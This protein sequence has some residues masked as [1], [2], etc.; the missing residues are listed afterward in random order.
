MS[1]ISESQYYIGDCIKTMQKEI[2]TESIDLVVTS[3]P[4][5]EQRV[6]QYGGIKESEYPEWTVTYME[7]VKRVLKPSGSVIIVI[8]P[9]ISDGVISD[10]MLKTRLLLRD[11][12]WLEC[13]ELIWVKTNSPPL[14]SVY[15]PRRAWESMH[16]FSKEKNPYCN[17][18][19]TEK[20]SMR[21]GLVSK[22]GVGD[23][24]QN[25]SQ[26]KVGIARVPDYVEVGTNLNDKN[27]NN[28]HPAQYPV[29]L[30][31]WIIE[32]LCPPN[33]TVLDPFLGSGTTGVAARGLNRNFYGIEKDPKYEDIIKARLHDEKYNRLQD[34]ITF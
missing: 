24:I 23:Y 1:K 17:T 11:A 33:G 6:N 21:V 7:E 30:A 8:R 3:P 34:W 15:R 28:N 27:K 20:K 29:E 18:K 25:A 10:Y 16:W 31:S 26:P 2:A 32:L 14:G 19:A 9:H 5:A 13:E 12:Q 4:Y 22:K